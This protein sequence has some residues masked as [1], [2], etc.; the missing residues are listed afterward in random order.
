MGLNCARG[1][2]EM[3]EHV[4]WLAQNWP[5]PLSGYPK[6]GL[7]KLVDGRT[8]YPLTAE[9]LAVW[10]ERFVAENGMNLIGERCNANGSKRRREVQ[11][12]A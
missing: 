6:A 10:L 4:R 2:Q 12:G 7:A 1:P 8:L 5:G 11:R 9:E 3:A